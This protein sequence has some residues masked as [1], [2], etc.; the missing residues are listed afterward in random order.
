[1]M[2]LSCYILRKY[3]VGYTK[4]WTWCTYGVPRDA[5]CLIEYRREFRRAR[6]EFAPR[7]PTTRVVRKS[8]IQ[9]S[10]DFIASERIPSEMYKYVDCG[11]ICPQYLLAKKAQLLS[12][13][14]FRWTSL[15]RPSSLSSP[16][17]GTARGRWALFQHTL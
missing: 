15:A 14:I 2:A 9:S 1:M 11:K 13:S 4:A 6:T 12:S 5:A 3:I 16:T 17:C 8:E 7:A 10:L